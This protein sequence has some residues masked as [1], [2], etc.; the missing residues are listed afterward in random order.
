[1]AGG[2]TEARSAAYG[3]ELFDPATERFTLL[4]RMQ[5]LRHSHTATLLA[6]G[7][8]LIVGGYGDGNR[9][10]THAELY[11]P[12]TNSFTPTG[13]LQSPRAGHVAIALL[14]GTVLIAGGLGPDWTFLSTAERFDPAT[15]KFSRTGTMTVPR[16]SHTAVRLDDGRVLIAGGHV[17]RRENITIYNTAELYDPGRGTLAPAGTMQVRRHKHDAVRLFDGRVLISGG[18]DERDSRGVYRSTEIFDPASGA[19]SAG[20]ALARPRYKHNGSS[21]VLPTG[22][23]LL[24]GGAPDAELYDPRRGTFAVVPGADQLTGQFSAVALLHAGGVL[25]TGG[26]GSDRGPQPSAWLY[27]P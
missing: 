14:D 12:A 9:V 21:L 4:P 1:V 11:D 3:A 2:F 19:F 15:G 27:R 24:A 8:V 16:E 17:G 23:V 25:I 6:S 18:A 22:L 26:Y 10:L 7:K 13:Q 20:P 5:S